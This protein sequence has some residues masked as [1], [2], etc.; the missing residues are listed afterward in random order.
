MNRSVT[1]YCSEK[2]AGFR[3]EVRRQHSVVLDKTGYHDSEEGAATAAKQ[4]MEENDFVLG[5]YRV[6]PKS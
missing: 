6:S 5:P 4:W 1:I 2:A 3:A